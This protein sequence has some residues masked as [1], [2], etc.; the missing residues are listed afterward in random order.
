MMLLLLSADNVRVKL[1]SDLVPHM[2]LVPFCLAEAVVRML[3]RVNQHAFSNTVLVRARRVVRVRTL[4]VL[5][6]VF[7]LLDGHAVIVFGLNDR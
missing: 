4:V 6:P 7:L 1:V 3:A 2:P 5:L